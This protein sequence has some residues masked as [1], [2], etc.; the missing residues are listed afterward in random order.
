[1]RHTFNAKF[2][3]LLLAAA[4]AAT[5]FWP[6]DGSGTAAGVGEP[7]PSA[8]ASSTAEPSA[9]VPIADGVSVSF[10]GTD[11]VFP[12]PERGFY[13]YA[14]DLATID[15]G[16]LRD[17]ADRGARLV[18]TP[19]DIS[20]YREQDL[21]PS[22]LED[23]QQGFASLRK[24]GLKAVLRF[25]Y[26]YP[27]TES[28]YLNAK[29]ASLARVQRHIEQ[30]SPI[31]DAN[32]DVIAVWQGGFIGAWGEW[33]TSSNGLDT[34]ANK[35]KVRDSLLAALPD[36]RQLQVR[37]P[38][39]LHTWFADEPSL[40]GDS[41]TEANAAEDAASRIGFHNDCFLSSEHDVGTY[42]PPEQSATLRAFMREHTA[43]TAS[44]GETCNQPE[45]VGARTTCADILREGADYHMAYLNRDYYQGFFDQWE[46]EGCLP[47]VS[48]RL[49]YRFALES[50]DHTA[51]AGAGEDVSV[52]VA[53][54]NQGWSRLINDRPLVLRLSPAQGGEAVD[55]PLPDLRLAL[56]GG[57]ESAAWQSTV[58]LPADL[59]PGTYRV[60]VGAP[61]PAPSLADR[62]AYAIRFA[63]ADAGDVRWDAASGFLTTGTEL[64]V[65]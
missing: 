47:D 33:H 2:T 62:A 65:E 11:D 13:R 12:N 61:D 15:A 44:G 51:S 54:E 22:Y 37:Y 48:R 21:P 58:A 59:P 40:D 35:L 5:S 26:N 43:V 30:L 23:L 45:P 1:M 52:N 39:D 36:N 9:A 38:G 28:D 18:Y 14:G 53:L 19:N 55:L 7:R 49:G 17:A 32:A 16:T 57:G 64:Q 63:N 20:A 10:A 34:P 46:S 60:Q 3:S 24:N 50:L 42:E 27:A 4:T 29:D 25:A 31:I 8:S 56:L 6:G 41:A